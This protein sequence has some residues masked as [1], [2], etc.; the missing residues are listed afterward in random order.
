MRQTWAN[1]LIADLKEK[2]ENFFASAPSR[3]K[4][5]SWINDWCAYSI[6]FGLIEL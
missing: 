3:D 2:G 4:V 1:K 5:M 6:S